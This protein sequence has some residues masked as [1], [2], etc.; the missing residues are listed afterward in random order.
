MI[1]FL[2]SLQI[3]AKRNVY[4]HIRVSVILPMQSSVSFFPISLS[5]FRIATFLKYRA[6]RLEY[7]LFGY[8][9]K[10]R[11][12]ERILCCCDGSSHKNITTKS[13]SLFFE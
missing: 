7:N 2:T 8:Q 3:A 5:I 13:V 1:V 4:R 11:N 6:K 9:A 12:M 10:I